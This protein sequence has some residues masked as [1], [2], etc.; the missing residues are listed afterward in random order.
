MRKKRQLP[1]VP[2]LTSCFFQ[3]GHC[4]PERWCFLHSHFANE[5]VRIF[6][7]FTCT[8]TQRAT[9]KTTSAQATERGC[10]V[11]S[12]AHHS[13]AQ[14]WRQHNSR[15]VSFFFFF[16]FFWLC[17]FRLGTIDDIS[18]SITF[19]IDCCVWFNAI[20]GSMSAGLKWQ[21]FGRLFILKLP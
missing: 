11:R 16:F 10:D 4:A 9:N 20:L 15:G 21:I 7:L 17:S 6:V 1:C 3:G 18:P 13:G 2:M 5:C 12:P 8:R 14:I 19:Y